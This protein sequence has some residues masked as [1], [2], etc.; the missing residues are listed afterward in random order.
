VTGPQPTVPVE[1]LDEAARWLSPEHRRWTREN[2]DRHPD[3]PFPYRALV[4][5]LDALDHLDVARAS[6]PVSVAA[7]AE[8][9]KSIGWLRE[10]ISGGPTLYEGFAADVLAALPDIPTARD[11]IDP[12]RLHAAYDRSIEDWSPGEAGLFEATAA[13]YDRLT[14]EAQTAPVGQS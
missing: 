3:H 4:P 8:A 1:A 2:I 10:F 12:K 5:V 13:E 7:L 11:G 14:T 6:A 9:I